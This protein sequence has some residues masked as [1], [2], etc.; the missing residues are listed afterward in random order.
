MYQV[1]EQTDEEQREM[2]RT[3]PVEEVIGMLIECNKVIRRMKPTV[4]MPTMQECDSCHC[5]PTV[6]YTTEN[7]RFCKGCKR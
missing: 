2:Y 1:V 7:G 6:I 4:V 3:I 5:H